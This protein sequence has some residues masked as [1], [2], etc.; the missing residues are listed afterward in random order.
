MYT[1]QDFIADLPMKSLKVLAK[2]FDFAEVSV[3]S[4]SVQEL[5]LDT[6]VREGEIILSTLIG[7]L[8]NIE[9]FK[10]FI[11]D[12]KKSQA[13]ALVV[14]FKDPAYQLDDQIV[15]LAI[16]IG[17]PLLCL[18]WEVR[19]A[20]VMKFT[21]QRIHE[22]NTENYKYTRDKLFTSYFA[23]K[24]LD[25]AAKILQSFFETPI[26]IAGK[27]L[28]I[29][30]KSCDEYD[31]E[32]CAIIDISIHQ[33]MWGYLYVCQPE[34]CQ[35]LLDNQKLIEQYIL[36]PLSMWFNKE[37][38]EKR[39]VL[40]IKNDFV[41][42]LASKNYTSFKEMVHQGA[43]LGFNL[44]ASYACIAFCVKPKDS[45]QVLDEY[46]AQSVQLCAFIE[47]L[48]VKERKRHRVK[49]MFADRGLE[50]I[51]YMDTSHVGN[52]VINEF[53]ESVIKLFTSKH[54]EL[55]LY[56]GISDISPENSELFHQLCQNAQ[57]ALQ[58]CMNSKTS[59]YI[60][61]YKDTKFHRI[62]SELSGNKNIKN[63]ASETLD[64]LLEHDKTSSMD[65]MNTLVEFIK[66]DGNTS[67]TARSLHLNRQSLL[68]RLKKI[69]SLTGLSLNQHQDLFLLELFTRIHSYY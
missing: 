24:T 10:K 19:F 54:P 48:I 20:D 65:L 15:H 4:I 11:Q 26:V 39:I 7:C 69:E 17:L 62:I 30:G 68:Y 23:S 50:F 67:Q 66:N 45:T 31:I 64:S 42:D 58:Y 47:E 57:L 37:N 22:K 56:C 8:D 38:I 27:N 6:F 60:F 29:K 36:M 33:V 5:P 43:K 13:A 1:L 44:S 21:I 32:N 53:V 34:K 18:P 12:I 9:I 49:V 52:E 28:K 14:C 35:K 41:W 25:D 55:Q 46:S 63:L 40:K 59:E 16:D 2:P 51:V 61:T 3:N